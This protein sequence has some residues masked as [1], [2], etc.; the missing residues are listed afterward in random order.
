VGRAFKKA[1]KW[2]KENIMDKVKEFLEDTWE[3]FVKPI[4]TDPIALIYSQKTL[5]NQIFNFLVFV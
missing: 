3:H 1:V 5:L 4:L 2:V